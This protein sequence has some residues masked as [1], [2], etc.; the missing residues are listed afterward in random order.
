MPNTVA[1]VSCRTPRVS[2]VFMI[3]QLS[4]FGVITSSSS[5]ATYGASYFTLNNLDQVTTVTSLFDQYRIVCVKVRFVAQQN[6]LGSA[7]G[8]M[9]YTVLDYDDGSALTSIAQARQ[10]ATCTETPPYMSV[11]RVFCPGIQVGADSGGSLVDAVSSRNQ[12]LD[13]GAPA[14]KHFG[15]KWALST[16]SVTAS[17]QQFVEIYVELRQV[18]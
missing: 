14:V 10:Y 15:V 7:A 8:G 6:A 11:E 2:N 18:R 17:W 5:G 1:T 13:C 12:W 9:L 4:D 3:R 16:S